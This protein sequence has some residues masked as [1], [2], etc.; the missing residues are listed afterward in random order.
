ME[1]DYFGHNFIQM[2]KNSTL[3]FK[4]NVSKF[5]FLFANIHF[6]KKTGNVADQGTK[7]SNDF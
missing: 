3:Q 6:C 1:T 2:L 7:A 4:G 5:L